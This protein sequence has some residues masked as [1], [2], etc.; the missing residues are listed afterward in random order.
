M[1]RCEWFLRTR[2]TRLSSSCV[3]NFIVVT[4]L[5]M[6]AV[7]RW[8]WDF[9]LLLVCAVAN[10]TLSANVRVAPLVFGFSP[11]CFFFF[12]F[13]SLQLVDFS[14]TVLLG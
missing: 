3:P 14:Q 7:C 4:T 12:F 2:G 5:V 11:G 9:G 8:L 1:L 6:A 13:L 10:E